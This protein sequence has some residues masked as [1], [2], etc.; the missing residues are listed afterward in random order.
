[1]TAAARLPAVTTTVTELV[2]MVID[3][4]EV[5]IDVSMIQDVLGPQSLT[6][7]PL[8]PPEVAGVLNLRGRIVTAIDLRRRLGIATAASFE[9]STHV[10]IDHNGEL[11]SILVDG[12]GDVQRHSPALFEPDV[13]TLGPT[14]REVAAGMYALD[15]GL[16]V[17][18]DVERVLDFGND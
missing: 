5:G 16:L 4:H 12:I 11:Y 9:T 15:R 13:S 1:M 7:V 3:H 6:P 17:V 14:W 2:G 18:L 8:A 10:V